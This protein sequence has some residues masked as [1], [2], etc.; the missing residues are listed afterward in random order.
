MSDGSEM[1]DLFGESSSDDTP[2]VNTSKSSFLVDFGVGGNLVERSMPHPVMT[3]TEI[4]V[5]CQR[6]EQ[7]GRFV[8]TYRECICL[9]PS[10]A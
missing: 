2:S 6:R 7:V 9:D 5:A 3:E 8:K 1:E 10:D 4:E